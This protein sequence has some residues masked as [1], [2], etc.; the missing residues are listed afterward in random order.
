MIAALLLTLP[1]LALQGAQGSSGEEPVDDFVAYAEGLEHLTGFQ[2]GSGCE[3]IERWAE[4]FSTDTLTALL[5]HDEPNVRAAA[6]VGLHVDRRVSALPEIAARIGDLEPAPPVRTPHWIADFQ[7]DVGSGTPPRPQYSEE[8]QTVGGIASS[9]VQL[10]FDGA[11]RGFALPSIRRAKRRNPRLRGFGDYWSER[12][13]RDACLGW[14]ALDLMCA[15]RGGSRVDPEVIER[16]AA[17]RQRVEAIED[18]YRS[19]LLL[20]LATTFENEEFPLGAALLAD[21]ER[22]LQAGRAIGEE[23]LVRFLSGESH[24]LSDPDC[25][26]G[27]GS[28]FPTGRIVLFL[29]GHARDLLPGTAPDTLLELEAR[30]LA[31]E[32]VGLAPRLPFA[33]WS[34]AAADLSGDRGAEVLVDAL[35]RYGDADVFDAQDQRAYLVMALW[36]HGGTEQLDRV[37]GRV[38][39]WFFAETPRKNSYGFGRHRVANAFMNESW[40]PVLRAVV[41]DDR[42]GT[43]DAF[44]FGRIAAATNHTLGRDVVPWNLAKREG[45]TPESIERLRAAW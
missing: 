29:L 16:V 40:R 41:A 3:E 42:I 14:L 10:Y 26:L 8:P 22:L 43:L 24:G 9:I 23:A 35:A 27:K 30:H 18:P 28:R 19:W 6:I 37:L 4:R 31:G 2:Y 20:A 13:E 5:E 45:P 21:E 34:I 39:D 1:P 15:V 25:A 7:V 38:L 33:A 44:T 17:V 11:A 32:S 12:A 36:R